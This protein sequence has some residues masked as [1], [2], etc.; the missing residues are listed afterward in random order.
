MM[1]WLNSN[2]VW[3]ALGAVALL[4]FSRGG[5]G[6]GHRGHDH[7]GAR[8]GSQNDPSGETMNRPFVSAAALDSDSTTAPQ[9]DHMHGLPSAGEGAL[10]TEHADH[11]SAKG[12]A[13]PRRHHHSC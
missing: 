2:W 1:N 8:E 7:R 3:L 6:M 9:N 5:C 4:M 10:T 11:D 12:E 13:G